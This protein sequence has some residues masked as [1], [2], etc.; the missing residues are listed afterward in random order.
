[1]ESPAFWIGVLGGAAIAAL[2]LGTWL[3]TRIVAAEARAED[4]EQARR[5]SQARTRELT[6]GT[7]ELLELVTQSLRQIAGDADKTLGLLAQ[8]DEAVNRDL[9]ELGAA[10][11]LDQVGVSAGMAHIEQATGELTGADRDLLAAGKE[12]ERR[13]EL[14]I[15]VV[16]SG[17]SEN[18]MSEHKVEDLVAAANQ[19][20]DTASAMDNVIRKLQASAGETAELSTEVSTEAERGYRAVHRTLDEIERIRSLVGGAR[21]R[22]DSLGERV[23]GI[24]HVV[25]VIQDITEKT[26]LLALNASIIA[27]QAGEHGRSFAVVANEIKALAQRTAASTKE[28]SEQIRGVQE[29]SERATSAMVDGVAAVGEGFQVA[30]AAGDALD[31]IRQRARAAQKRVQSMTRTLRQQN[32]AAVQVV[33][34]AAA[35]SERAASFAVAVRGQAG[36]AE[37]LRASAREIHSDA[38]LIADLLQHHGVT[39]TQT[40]AVIGEVMG[41]LEGIGRHNRELKQAVRAIA[42]GSERGRHLGDDLAAHWAAVDEAA[43]QLADHVESLRRTSGRG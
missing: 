20:V 4:S 10:S 8:A 15:Q 22:I 41:Q 3:R 32:S 28:I 6:A 25:K 34:S 24:G 42:A 29:E 38:H 2:A 37:R 18:R 11:E 13:A 26:N 36:V 12:L 14:L 35:V 7:V 30:I 19:S 9:A 33:D 27:A 40:A 21:E 31:A 1:M 39:S 43:A 16:D 17:G 23:A 5:A